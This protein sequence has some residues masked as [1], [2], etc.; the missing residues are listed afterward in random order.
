M[1]KFSEDDWD[2]IIRESS[3][4]S[5]T[6]SRI[7]FLS[8]KFLGIAYAESTLIGS[9]E[10]K[11]VFVI[12]LAAVDCFTF[13]EYVESMRLS[14]SFSGFSGNLRQIRYRSGIVSF[15]TRNHF[16]TDWRKF[17][18]AFI[19]DVTQITGNDYATSVQKRLNVSED[20]ASILPGIPSV[21]RNINFIPAD[22]IGNVILNKLKTGDYIGIYSDKTGL[23]V[24]HVGI[25]IKEGN[26]IFLRHASSQKEYRE[27]IDQDF[28]EYIAHKPG[29]VVLRPREYYPIN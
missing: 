3:L 4:I 29:I 5:D 28:K 18:K 24:S 13:L 1:G 11:E 2:N 12:N 23:D 7:D 15:K 19:Q 6:G 26:D 20:Y 27:V 22:K 21:D 14:K 9:R 25:L 10:T 16:F 8:S 17:N